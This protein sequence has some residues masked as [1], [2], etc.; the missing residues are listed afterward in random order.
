MLTLY[1]EL[2]KAATEWRACSGKAGY[3]TLGVTQIWAYIQKY[4]IQ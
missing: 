2:T 1:L 3:N 4:F